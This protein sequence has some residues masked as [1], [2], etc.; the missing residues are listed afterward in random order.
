MIRKGKDRWTYAPDAPKKKP[1]SWQILLPAGAALFAV[2]F[3]IGFLFSREEREK[4]PEIYAGFTAYESDEMV[5]VIQ[6]DF[7]E[8]ISYRTTETVGP[9]TGLSGERYVYIYYIVYTEHDENVYKYTFYKYLT[10]FGEITAG[11]VVL[12][13]HGITTDYTKESFL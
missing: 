7:P 12:K 4:E 5:K 3:L 10:D 1:K 2:C 8:E 9:V 6:A 11:S 13:S